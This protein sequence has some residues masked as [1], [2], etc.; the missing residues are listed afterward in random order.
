MGGVYRWW[1]GGGGTYAEL[2][3]QLRTGS[4]EHVGDGTAVADYGAV[5]RREP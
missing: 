5:E 1:R 4:D 2:H 3:V